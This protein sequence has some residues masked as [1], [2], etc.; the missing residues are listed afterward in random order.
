LLARLRA[1]TEV[2]ADTAIEALIDPGAA[3]L[4]ERVEAGL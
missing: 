4:A 1:Y 3:A 2:N